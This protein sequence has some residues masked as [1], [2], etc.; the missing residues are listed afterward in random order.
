MIGQH[1]CTNYNY[2]QTKAEHATD[3]EKIWGQPYKWIRN[4]YPPYSWKD[5]KPPRHWNT[6]YRRE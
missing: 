2:Q 6:N 5:G 3:V 4:A 1:H